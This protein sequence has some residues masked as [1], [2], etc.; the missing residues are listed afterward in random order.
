MSG[1]LFSRYR[2]SV[3]Y[4]GLRR[5]DVLSALRYHQIPAVNTILVNQANRV[6][7]MFN[8]MENVLATRPGYQ[9]PNPNIQTQWKSWIKGRADLARTKAETYLKGNLKNLKELGKGYSNLEIVWNILE[10]IF[11]QISI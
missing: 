9:R 1:K 3:H 10:E 5:S 2:T 7:N 6:G 4:P 11:P 8:Q